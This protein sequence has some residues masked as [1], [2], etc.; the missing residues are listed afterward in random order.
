MIIVDFTFAAMQ[1]GSRKFVN[2]EHD[3]NPNVGGDTFLR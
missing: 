3:H 2:Q 1:A